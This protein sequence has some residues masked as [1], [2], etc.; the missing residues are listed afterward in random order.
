MGKVQ[1]ITDFGAFVEIIPGTDG[2]LHVSEIARHRVQDVR[3]ELK[4]G[5]QLLVKV[6]S[7]DPSGKIRLS[8]KALLAEEEGGE[9]GE[10]AQE[11]PAGHT[12]R[13]HRPHGHDRGPG[14]HAGRGGRP[15]G[16]GGHDRRR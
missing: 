2:L 1:R 8:R 4:E 9:A 11:Q 16:P 15:G 3:D 13:P 7:I 10:A 6:I 12:P 14:G 5:D